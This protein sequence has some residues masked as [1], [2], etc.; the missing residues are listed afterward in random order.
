MKK[1]ALTLLLSLG[2]LVPLLAEDSLLPLSVAV[3]D[4]QTSGEKLDKK[5]SEVALLLGTHLSTAPNVLLVER[6]EIEKILSEQEIGLGGAVT[7]ESAAKV[8]GRTN[9]WAARV[10][11]TCTR[12]PR[13]CRRRTI[14]AD[15]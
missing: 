4:F 14:S 12:M 5:G 11:T 7:P 9:S 1:I 3:L 13:S 2:L 15:L 8:R 6:Q 10:I